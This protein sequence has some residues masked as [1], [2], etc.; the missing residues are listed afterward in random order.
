[1]NQP[2]SQ[3]FRESLDIRH[4][5]GVKGTFGTYQKS[6]IKLAKKENHLTLLWKAR[7]NNIIPK[8]LRLKANGYKKSW[9]VLAKLY[10]ENV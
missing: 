4:G 9:P 2:L 7:Q 10:Q 8:G 3:T 1:M 6:L 5:P